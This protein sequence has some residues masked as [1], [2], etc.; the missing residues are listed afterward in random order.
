M[1]TRVLL[2]FALVVALS[3]GSE[4]DENDIEVEDVP[5][6]EAD[7]NANYFT[8]ET[9]QEIQNLD[10]YMNNRLWACNLLTLCKLTHEQVFISI[11]E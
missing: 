10:K 4:G 8:Q 6:E 2:F 7:R 5:N 11:I 1:R 3:F 9:L